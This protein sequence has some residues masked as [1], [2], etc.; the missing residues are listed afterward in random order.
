M[1][2]KIHQLIGSL[3]LKNNPGGYQLFSSCPKETSLLAVGNFSCER[4]DGKF[5][6][7][8]KALGP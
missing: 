8:F 5:L 2:L 1:R 3:P 7:G 6:L 4:R